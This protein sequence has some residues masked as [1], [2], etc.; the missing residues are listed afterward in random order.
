MRD[1]PLTGAVPRRNARHDCGVAR[2]VGCAGS[3]CVER[4]GRA[5]R[6]CRGRALPGRSFHEGHSSGG[7]ADARPGGFDR[8]GVVRRRPG[9]SP[10]AARIRDCVPGG[11]TVPDPGACF[12]TWAMPASRSGT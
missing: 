12:G 4:N 1:K 7:R 3:W 6:G 5:L 10:H 2:R 11:I 8:A 9:K